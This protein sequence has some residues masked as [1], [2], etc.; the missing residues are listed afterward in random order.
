[1]LFLSVFTFFFQ[2]E[3]GIRDFH[4]TGLQTCALPIYSYIFHLLAI[5]CV[6]PKSYFHFKTFCHASRHRRHL[7]FYPIT[8]YIVPTVIS[9][10]QIG[11]ASCRERVSICELVVLLSVAFRKHITIG[12]R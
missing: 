9:I 5:L 1:L 10:T 6:D 2:A 7:L 11:R 4:V 12:I 3:D 8:E